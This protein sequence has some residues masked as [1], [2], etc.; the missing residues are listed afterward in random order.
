MS[1]DKTSA[2]KFLDPGNDGR[3]KAKKAGSMLFLPLCG[4]A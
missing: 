1:G 2:P 4:S 3:M